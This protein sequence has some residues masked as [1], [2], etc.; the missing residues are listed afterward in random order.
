MNLLALKSRASPTAD[1]PA[2]S[3][4]IVGIATN[5]GDRLNVGVWV[6][7]EIFNENFI[8]NS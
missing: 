1:L 7:R 3:V 2:P 5:K 6:R 8:Y 4:T